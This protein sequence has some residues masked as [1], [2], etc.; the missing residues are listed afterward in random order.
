[1][2]PNLMF[3]EGIYAALATPFLE[4]GVTVDYD[5]IPALVKHL[6][7]QGISGLYVCGTTGQWKHLTTDERKKIFE[8]V[9]ET[10][11]DSGLETVLIAHVGSAT[12]EDSIELG[13]HAK[14]HGARAI[15]AITPVKKEGKLSQEEIIE[16][17]GNLAKSVDHPLIVYTFP[18]ITGVS[19]D[20]RTIEK[21]SAIPQI[22]GIK[23][24][25]E[26]FYFL[27][28]MGS[29]LSPSW[30]RFM[31]KD[32]SFSSSLFAGVRH[33]I[34]STYNFMAPLYI[35]MLENYG[36][37]DNKKVEELQNKA[38][39]VIDALKGLRRITNNEDAL[40]TGV[41]FA[42]EYLYGIKLGSY[43]NEAKLMV[44]QTVELRRSLDAI[45]IYLN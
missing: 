8:I 6:Q 29:K 45:K 7:S 16:Y 1:M 38:N 33:A 13:T 44:E 34:G 26:K 2:L 28:R 37:R 20:E 18:G 11:K 30:K 10:V 36:K 3:Q 42:V 5:S 27:E 23:F 24:T 40:L 31:G 19:L 17:Y 43:R 14:M 12:L 25:D 21:L 4:D 15:S 41:R 32:E 39:D 35:S 9:S 22:E